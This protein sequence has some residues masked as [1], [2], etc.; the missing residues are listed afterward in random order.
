M[1]QLWPI[2]TQVAGEERRVLARMQKTKNLL[3]IIPLG[4]SYLKTNLSKVNSPTAKF[5]CFVFGDIVIQ[6][7]H[8]A[9]L[10][11]AIISLMIPRRVR[12][13]ASFIP[14]AVRLPRYWRALACGVYPPFVN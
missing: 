14:S 5:L 13:N 3:L 1:T 10:V 8:A 7:V 2:E 9:V 11:P 6:Y 12:F 4:S